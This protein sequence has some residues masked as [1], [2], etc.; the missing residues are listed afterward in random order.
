MLEKITFQ[1][2]LGRAQGGSMALQ[3]AGKWPKFNPSLNNDCNGEPEN[4][5]L[6]S[7]TMKGVQGLSIL[8]TS[9]K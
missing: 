5:A 7:E 4:I 9:M 2:A 3:G 8:N 6:N 1:H